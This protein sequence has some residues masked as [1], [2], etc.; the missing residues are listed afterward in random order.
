MFRNGILA[1]SGRI[2][3]IGA[4]AL[5]PR[6]GFSRSINPGSWVVVQLLS[7]SPRLALQRITVSML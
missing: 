1:A 3:S 4:S 5:N 7:H 2:F 6:S